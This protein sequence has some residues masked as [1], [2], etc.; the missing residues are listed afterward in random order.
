MTYITSTVS[1][2]ISQSKSL[3]WTL[4]SYITLPT[5]NHGLGGEGVNSWQ[6]IVQFCGRVIILSTVTKLMNVNSSHSIKFS[7]VWLSGY[8]LVW[9]AQFHPCPETGCIC[10]HVS[11]GLFLSSIF[12]SRSVCVSKEKLS[13]TIQYKCKQRGAA[14]NLRGLLKCFG[15]PIIQLGMGKCTHASLQ[16]GY[17]QGERSDRKGTSM[18]GPMEELSVIKG[19]QRLAE[20]SVR[21]RKILSAWV[22]LST[23]SGTQSP[24]MRRRPCAWDL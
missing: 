22:L 13:G 20:I 15:M 10:L 19:G 2:F 18:W 7:I 4:G 1:S 16:E 17:L 5:G 9:V 23:V 3:G 8:L 11:C 21:G 6:H 14:I 24:R 12:C